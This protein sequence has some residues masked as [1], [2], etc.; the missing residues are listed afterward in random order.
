MN[1]ARCTRLLHLL[2]AARNSPQRAARLWAQLDSRW[3]LTVQ[4]LVVRSYGAQYLEKRVAPHMLRLPQYLSRPLRTNGP[5]V[6]SQRA[7][8][9]RVGLR[10]GSLNSG[11]RTGFRKLQLGL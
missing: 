9:A 10:C 5:R 6:R 11:W 3:C 1:P 7:H 8:A 4:V 2:P